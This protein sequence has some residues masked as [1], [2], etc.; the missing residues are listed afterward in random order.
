MHIFDLSRT[1]VRLDTTKIPTAT[2][3]ERITGWSP[4]SDAL[5]LPEEIEFFN[6][7]VGGDGQKIGTRTG[8]GGGEVSFKLMANSTSIPF[9]MH[10]VEHL[11]QPNPR[12]EVFYGLIHD[13]LNDFTITLSSG[14]LV[15]GPAGHTLGVGETSPLTFTFNFERIIPDYSKDLFKDDFSPDAQ[16]RVPAL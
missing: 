12:Y 2:T 7:A 13:E 16:T 3:G 15:K 8:E 5:M 1:N 6:I 11:L 9:L 10:Y 14:L 4:D